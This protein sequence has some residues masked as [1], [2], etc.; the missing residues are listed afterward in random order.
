MSA[1]SM[2]V[3]TALLLW[4]ISET[5]LLGQEHAPG[6]TLEVSE[7]AA[8]SAPANTVR[9]AFAVEVNAPRAGDAVRQNAQ[10]TDTLLRTL[11]KMGR[12]EDMLETSG[13]SLSPVYGRG[14]PQEPTAYRVRNMVV[15]RSKQIDRAGAYIDAAAEAGANRIDSVAFSHDQGE[16]LRDQAAVKALKKVLKTAEKLAQAAGMTIKRI[17]R[18]EYSPPGASVQYTRAAFAEAGG[19]PTPIEAGEFSVSATVRVMFEIQD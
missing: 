19:A 2:I 15:L 8:V 17:Q 13:Y 6:S 10:Q 18:I 5:P 11:K 9:I 12:S 7:T 4:G 1:V 16:A 3:S 14:S